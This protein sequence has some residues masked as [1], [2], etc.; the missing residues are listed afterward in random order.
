MDNTDGHKR[1]TRADDFSIVG[2]SER[3]HDMMTETIMKTCEDL[4]RKGKRLNQADPNE[5]ADL[6]NK[7]TPSA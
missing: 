5:L 6:I 1:L 2:G 4:K 3:T 7:N